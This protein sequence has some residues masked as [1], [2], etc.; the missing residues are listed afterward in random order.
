MKETFEQQAAFLVSTLSK[1][2]V[3][4]LGY[5]DASVEWVDGF[6]ERQRARGDASLA[7]GLTNVVG[8]Y[9]GEC[10]IRNYGGQWRADDDGAW[11]VF[12]DTQNAA[13]PFTKVAK[14]FA[15][16][17]EDSIYSFYRT[18]PIVF[19]RSGDAK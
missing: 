1:D 5:D 12:F 17:A 9:L 11:G 2:G 19:G 6:V 15:N 13:F 7:Q 10:I 16:G 8:A 4:E 18:I 3:V 14:Q